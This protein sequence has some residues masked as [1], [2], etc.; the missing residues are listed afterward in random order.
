MTSG[1]TPSIQATLAD[2]VL[3][4]VFHRP[5]KK[6]AL[7]VE[8]YETLN[9][10]LDRAEGDAAVKVMLFSGTGGVFTAG[11]DLED[12]LQRPPRDAGAPVFGFMRR[13]VVA[14]KPVIAAVEGLAIGLG[15]TMLLHCDLVYAGA[16]AR[17]AFPFANLGLVPEAGSSFL[18]PQI[19]GRHRASEALYFGDPLSA[20]EAHELGFVNAVLC[21]GQALPHALERAGRLARL[22]RGSVVGT[23]QMTRPPHE[24]EALLAHMQ[25]E[26]SL[27]LQRL[28]GAAAQEAF[29]A[30]KDKRRP[31]F[32]EMD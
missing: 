12:F 5:E 18:L 13:L 10:T 32:T 19:A 2:G 7:T 30:F 25:R 6:N 1:A 26:T 9:A 8:M 4:I 23:K 22:P 27:F 17:F 20:R 16:D 29:T 24:Q 31:D 28:G 21:A 14:R 15:T 11:N 3:H